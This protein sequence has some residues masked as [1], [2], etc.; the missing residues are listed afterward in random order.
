M[1][2]STISINEFKTL[3]KILGFTQKQF[4]DFLGLS[5]QA[6]K[7]WVK[8]GEIPYYAEL[9]IK[10]EL[11]LQQYKKYDV[12]LNEMLNSRIKNILFELQ[13]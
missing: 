2:K 8:D 12:C 5:E 3:L 6:L 1:R 9:I 13:K 7:K 4:A 11:E 10:K